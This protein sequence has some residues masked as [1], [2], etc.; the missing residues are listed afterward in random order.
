VKLLVCS[1]DAAVLGAVSSFAKGNLCKVE[2][3]ADLAD[4]TDKIQSGMVL[5]L[6][7]LDMHQNQAIGLQFL[8][9]LD[10]IRPELPLIVLD[11]SGELNGRSEALRGSARV[12][13]GGVI[14]DRQLE[15]VIR[16]NLA[17]LNART[18]LDIS[19][20][21]VEPV[22]DEGFFIGISPAMRRLR[23]QVARFAEIDVPIFI[24]GEP[25]SGRETTARLLHKLS[26]R[27]GFAF[28]RVNCAALPED[29]LD[30]EIF[31]YETNSAHD[32][33]RVR[34][35]KL[36]CCNRGTI[37]LD[38][39]AEMPLSLQ[40]KLVQALLDRTVTREPGG[41]RV[42]VDTRIITASSLSLD[43]AVA[44]HRLLPRLSVQLSACML[45][46]P[47]LRERKE[48]LPV[49]SRHFM[50]RIA[51]CY[52]LPPREIAQPVAEAWQEHHWPGNLNELEES[53]KRYL[54]AG[55]KAPGF[56]GEAR[57]REE[58]TQFAVPVESPYESRVPFLT[59]SNEGI[60]GY[61][62][63]RSLL[64]SVKEEAERK[65]IALAL[66]KTGWNRKAAARLLKT[67]YR[68]V[69]YKI[70]QYEMSATDASP[71]SSNGDGPGKVKAQSQD[72]ENMRVAK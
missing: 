37:F 63:L 12:Y 26:V 46:V 62:S 52:G 10:R 38:E 51:R 44:E 2:S 68:S 42:E 40:E 64:R 22:G 9:A 54:V 59:Q 15:M 41:E 1:R 69:L 33:S 5:D 45:Q 25:G 48:E 20:D 36:E 27:S 65:A 18:D 21:D 55:D 6:L 43:R 50:H 66:E 72:L 23:A 57:S 53:V 39:V 3:M 7:V 60:Y 13:L 56:E 29:L 17:D 31:G 34:A 4:A 35:G 11:R 16:K 61:K 8:R 30:R 28:A 32:S 47:A 24:L 58:D 14:S 49:L 67:S 70:D 19:S 71:R